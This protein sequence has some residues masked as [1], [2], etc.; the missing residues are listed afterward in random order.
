LEFIPIIQSIY[1][2]ALQFK[3]S[4]CVPQQCS[5]EDTI[6]SNRL[7]FQNLQLVTLP[8]LG[9]RGFTEEN[10]RLEIDSYAKGIM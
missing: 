9:S 8:T 7:I 3:W 1:V 5:I 10:K 2:G 6:E 4:M